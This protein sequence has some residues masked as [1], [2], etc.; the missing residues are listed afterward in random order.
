MLIAFGPLDI[1]LL[2]TVEYLLTELFDFCIRSRCYAL[3]SEAGAANIHP[4]L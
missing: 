2:P 3:H 4:Y 1:V